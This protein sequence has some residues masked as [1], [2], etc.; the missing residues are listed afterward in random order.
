MI[1]KTFDRA[2][3][4]I[5]TCIHHVHTICDSRNHTEIVSD[6]HDCGAKALLHALDNLKN[7]GLNCHVKCRRRFIG[8]QNLRIVGNCDCDY[9]TLTHAAR[10]LVRILPGPIARL[11]NSNNVEQ[12]NRSFISVARRKILVRPQHFRNLITDAMYWVQC[13]QRIL[14]NHRKQSSTY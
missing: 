13:R 8:Y 5:A 14:K 11:R 10:K 7:L 3:F 9:H 12:F 1:K 2:L 6:Q 4:D